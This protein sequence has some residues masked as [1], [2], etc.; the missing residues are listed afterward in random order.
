SGT[1]THDA[2]L[3][4]IAAPLARFLL[5]HSDVECTF[6]GA[7]NLAGPLQGLGNV[8]L[9]PL[10]PVKELYPFV[11]QHDLCLVPLEP[12]SFN[13]CKSALKFIECGAVSVP[14]LA[15]PRREYRSVL[16]HGETGFLAEDDEDSWCGAL[17]RIHADPGALSRVAR[18][19]HETVLREHSIA[20]RQARLADFWCRWFEGTAPTA[21][22]AVRT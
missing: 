12:S 3:R 19:A 8:K 2:D 13:D 1:P 11:A 20:G 15:S 5:E 14:V 21:R 10:L 4:R 7:L 22:W 16:R 18:A 6:L 9:H 17:E